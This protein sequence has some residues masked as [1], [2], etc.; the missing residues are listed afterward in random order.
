MHKKPVIRFRDVTT[1][2]IQM[3]NLQICIWFK[4]VESLAG[5]VL[6]GTTYIDKCIGIY[7]PCNEREY[8]SI[9][10]QWLYREEVLRQTWA[11]QCCVQLLE[12]S[13]M[14]TP[15][16]EVQSSSLLC[17]TGITSTCR[18]VNVWCDDHKRMQMVEQIQLILP[19]PGIRDE[20]RTNVPVTNFSNKPLVL[21]KHMCLAWGTGPPECIMETERIDGLH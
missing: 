18:K 19:T 21:Y 11:R 2:V 3:R 4:I 5:S 7:F 14:N 16:L 12:M 13:T 8:Q 20:V 9:W 6:L 1:L 15:Q 17:L 10:R